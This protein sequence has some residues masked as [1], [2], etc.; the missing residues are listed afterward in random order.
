LPVLSTKVSLE[1]A[2][3]TPVAAILL[4]GWPAVNFSG[5]AF[6]QYLS[7]TRSGSPGPA[8]AFPK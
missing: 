2:S 7:T 8:A 6:S 3:L 5:Q 4:S 1:N